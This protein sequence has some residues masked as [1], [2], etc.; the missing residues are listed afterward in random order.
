M[1]CVEKLAVSGSFN[2]SPEKF[3]GYKPCSPDKKRNII[4]DNL[5]RIVLFI[6]WLV[7]IFLVLVIF[8]I[9]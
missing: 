9:F 5:I 6:G 3:K 2:Y 8:L 7:F 4:M 1:A